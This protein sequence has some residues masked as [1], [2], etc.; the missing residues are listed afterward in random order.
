LLTVRYSVSNV[1]PLTGAPKG[2]DALRIRPNMPA[3]PARSDVGFVSM[4]K[5]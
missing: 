4:E 3:T 2:I 5:K 1:E